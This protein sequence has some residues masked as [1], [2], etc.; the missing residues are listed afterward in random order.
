MYKGEIINNIFNTQRQRY[1]K[2]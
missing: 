2:C 1:L